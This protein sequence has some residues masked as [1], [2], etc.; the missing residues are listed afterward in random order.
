MGRAGDTSNNFCIPD[1]AFAYTPL[2][3]PKPHCITRQWNNDGTITPWEAP[4]WVTSITQVAKNWS[5]YGN[6][7]GFT[8]HFK[9]HLSI[10]GY[11]GD[12]SVPWA[13]NEYVLNKK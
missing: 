12:Y 10:G 9:L 13:T 3:Y 5:Q 7:I 1:G 2:A 4:E 6:M 11:Y 8:G